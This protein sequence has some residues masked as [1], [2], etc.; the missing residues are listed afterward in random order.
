MAARARTHPLTT[1]TAARTRHETRA[2]GVVRSC[3]RQSWTVIRGVALAGGRDGTAWPLI[4]V[5]MQ[6]QLGGGKH[7]R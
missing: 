2:S 5:R 6:T 4:Q 1:V 3:I 7:T